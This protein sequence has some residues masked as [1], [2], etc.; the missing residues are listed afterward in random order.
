MLYHK[1]A[2]WKTH[3][4]RSHP[5]SRIPTSAL[6]YFLPNLH[7]SADTD[8][9]MLI[10]M[11]MAKKISVSVWCVLLSLYFWWRKGM[12][13]KGNIGNTDLRQPCAP[14]ANNQATTLALSHLPLLHH[15]LALKHALTMLIMEISLIIIST[16]MISIAHLETAVTTR[17]L[18]LK[19]QP[20][21]F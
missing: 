16:M 8:L 4:E 17:P 11:L 6:I 14:V 12:V 15:G 18:S 21:P 5:K 1:R 19:L 7:I 13:K 2:S 9:P 3:F 10:V 20:S